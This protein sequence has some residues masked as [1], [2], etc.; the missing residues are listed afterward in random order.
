MDTQEIAVTLRAS[1]ALT[2]N[3]GAPDTWKTHSLLMKNNE[4]GKELKAVSE[5]RYLGDMLSA[6]GGC[7]LQTAIACCKC[8]WGKFC[9]LLPLPINRN[10]L[11]LMC[12][13]FMRS[14]MLH[15]AETWAMTVATQNPF[16]LMTRNDGSVI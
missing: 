15:A 5:F 4:G 2:L 1:C 6:G 11:V 7:R 16:S 12:S 9:Q 13:T 8:S 10:P 3:S 14:V